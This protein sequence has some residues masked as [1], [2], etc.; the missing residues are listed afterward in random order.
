MQSFTGRPGLTD[1]REAESGDEADADED[2]GYSSASG[3]SDWEP[4]DE[5]LVS[6]DDDEE[7][8]SPF[9]P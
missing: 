8:V 1:Q 7:R 3:G 2:A 5:D 4:A 6:S 9:S